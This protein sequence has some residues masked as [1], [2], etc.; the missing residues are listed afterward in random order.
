M[1]LDQLKTGLWGYKK[2]SVYAYITNL[3]EEFFAKLSEK[4]SQQKKSE[5][6]YQARIADLEQEL[7]SVREQLAQQQSEKMEIASTLVAAT[8]YGETLRKEAQ[9]KVQEEREEWERALAAME[10]ELDQYH[11]QIIE[12]RETLRKFLLDAE[13]QSQVLEQQVETVQ[14]A[15]PSHNMTLFERKRTIET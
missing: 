13:E 14:S 15:C 2:S 7:R 4:D 11:A 12:I 8:Q 6:Q 5:E 3:E 10:S 1:N 9:E